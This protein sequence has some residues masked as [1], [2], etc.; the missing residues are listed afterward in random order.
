MCVG[1]RTVFLC[2]FCKQN[3][4]QT[5]YNTTKRTHGNF[6]K[7]K[8]TQKKTPKQNT[9]T[10]RRRVREKHRLRE[11]KITNKKTKHN[12]EKMCS[13]FLVKSNR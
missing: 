11:C 1:L 7:N 6:N 3:K 12:E 13:I 8:E 9:K 5:L 4:F 2:R 10:A